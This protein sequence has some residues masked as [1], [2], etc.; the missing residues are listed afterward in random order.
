[1]NDSTKNAAC[2]FYNYP[3]NDGLCKD[4]ISSLYVFGDNR[5][6]ADG[7]KKTDQF[8]QFFKK[9]IARISEKCK[10]IMIDLY[11][12]YHFPPCDVTLSEP[13]PRRICRSSCEY[14]D[15]DLCKEEMIL[16]RQ[17]AEAV[18]VLDM[19]MINCSL[20]DVTNGGN[21]PECYQYHSLPGACKLL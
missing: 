13:Q 1:M 4:I 3:V 19:N 21:S 11:C 10:P 12:R 7:E 9:T 16:I 8:Q 2:I 15:Q 17:T 6:L 5:T 18:P 20:Y 14:L